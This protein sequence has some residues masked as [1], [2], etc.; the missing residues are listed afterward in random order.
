[1]NSQSQSSHHYPDPE[2]DDNCAVRL[3][4]QTPA[5]GC[6]IQTRFDCQWAGRSGNRSSH[7][8]SFQTFQLEILRNRDRD[9][10]NRVI[11]V[12]SS[13]FCGRD[14]HCR[15][16]FEGN[17]RGRNNECVRWSEASNDVVNW[18]SSMRVAALVN[19]D[20]QLFVERFQIFFEMK[21]R[22]R[23]M[24]SCFLGSVGLP[25]G[26][27]HSKSVKQPQRSSRLRK[28]RLLFLVSRQTVNSVA[29]FSGWSWSFGDWKSFSFKNTGRSDIS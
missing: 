19:L 16:Y 22:I 27:W 8:W 25:L 7:W 29:V 15:S 24:K 14:S 20:H 6:S 3:S 12:G 9:P 1:V 23:S 11:T 10:A 5:S 13:T 2:Y 4:G 28:S 17:T 21:S 26:I 18:H